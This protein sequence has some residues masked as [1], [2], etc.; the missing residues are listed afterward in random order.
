MLLLIVAGILFILAILTE[1][2]SGNRTY[3][4]V[5]M[6]LGGLLTMVAG[7]VWLT[8]MTNTLLSAWILT[9]G[10]LIFLIGKCDTKGTVVPEEP[11]SVDMKSTKSKSG[12]PL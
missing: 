12:E 3:G 4:P 9:A 5:F 11:C 7:A 8:V 6:S 1:W 10:F 2:G